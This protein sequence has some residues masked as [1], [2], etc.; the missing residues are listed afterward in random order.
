VFKDGHDQ[1]VVSLKWRKAGETD[2]QKTPMN[3]TEN[4]RWEGTCHFIENA[5]HEYTIEAWE[6]AF[7]SWQVEY[8]KKYTAGNLDLRTELDEG[9]ILAEKAAG[10]ATFKQDKERLLA[11]SRQLKNADAHFGAQ[12]AKNPELSGLMA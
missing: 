4:D 10:R 11:F 1:I 5:L 8:S 2:W 12:L 7:K 3:P 6:D 9:S